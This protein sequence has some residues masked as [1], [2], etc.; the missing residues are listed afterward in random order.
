[1]ASRR[2]SVPTVLFRKYF[3][4]LLIDSPTSALAAK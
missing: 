2:F 3:A 1:M 4:G